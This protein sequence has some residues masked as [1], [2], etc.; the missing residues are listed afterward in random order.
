[1]F[2][3]WCCCLNALSETWALCLPR[4]RFLLSPPQVAPAKVDEAVG[5]AAAGHFHLACAAAWEGQHGCACETGINHPNQVWGR[6]GRCWARGAGQECEQGRRH[7]LAPLLLRGRLDG[8]GW[9]AHGFLVVGA[10]R[11]CH[12]VFVLPHQVTAP[13][14]PLSYR[15][16]YFEE[17]RKARAAQE[18]AVP[19]AVAAAPAAAAAAVQLPRTPGAPPVAPPPPTVGRQLQNVLGSNG[20]PP[21]SA[22]AKVQR[23]A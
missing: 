10:H 17:S 18:G 7:A 14:R 6:R 16:Q 13:A 12:S 19:A 5:A 23:L 8:R 15:L 3:R 11:V 2:W 21:S 20:Q 4:C 9:R 22:P 1:V